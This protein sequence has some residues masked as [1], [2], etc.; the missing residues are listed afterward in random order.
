MKHKTDNIWIGQK[1]LVQDQEFLSTVDSE[2]NSDSS[3]LADATS[4]LSGNR[5]DFLKFLGFGLGAATIAAGCD[6]PVKKAIPYV[7]KPDEIVPGIANYYASSFVN[8]GDYCSILVKTREG[9]PIKIEG[10]ALS[11]VTKGGTSARAQASVLSLYDTN[12]IKGPQVKDGARW[13]D[14]TWQ[15]IDKMMVPTLSSNG[16]RIISHTNMSPTSKKAI[17]EFVAKYPNTK[18]VTYDP[19]SASALLDANQL[20]FGVRAVP[21][22]HFDKAS[23]IVSF[24]AD[25]LGTWISPIEYAADFAKGRAINDVTKASMSRLIQVENHMSLTGSNADNRILVRPSEQ[26]VAIA[27][28][29]NE[30]V[31]GGPS[32]DGLND[33]AKKAISKV[34][35]ELKSKQGS[36]LVVSASNNVSEQLMINAINNA[37]GNYGTTLDISMPSYQRQ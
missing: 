4:S 5:R 27:H 8:G 17:A 23:V 11:P 24:N 20:N 16:I 28:L 32:S 2:F 15:E 19:V 22:Y 12:R 25:F 29:Y 31:G 18:V 35:S 1:D 3:T 13:K 6:I 30:I 10:N 26:G 33:K 14:T 21:S 7:I 37:L 36:S 9:R 34:A